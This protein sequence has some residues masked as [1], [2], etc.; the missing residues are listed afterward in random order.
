MGLLDDAIREHL[1]LKRRRGAD[2]SEVARQEKEALDPALPA[3]E[4]ELS[5]PHPESAEGGD[6]PEH[7][8]IGEAGHVEDDDMR[9]PQ[10]V[11]LSPSGQE[12]AEIDMRSVLEAGDE[13]ASPGT[14]AAPASAAHGG[15][16]DDEGS[17]EW[18][19]ASGE[20][21]EQPPAEIPGQERLTFE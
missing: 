17:F 14:H 5:E 12:T 10:A 2:A 21:D 15:R 1:E 7:D 20:E 19:T 6:Y 4:A 8:P 13:P 16:A 11:D 18:E 3:H 9:S